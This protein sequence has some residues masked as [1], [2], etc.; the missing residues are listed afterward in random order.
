MKIHYE[1]IEEGVLLKALHDNTRLN[2]NR[3]L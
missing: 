1:G 3:Q 2:Q